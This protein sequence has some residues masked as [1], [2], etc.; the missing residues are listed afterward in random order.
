MQG[1]SD[2]R[3]SE[4][5]YWELVIVRRLAFTHAASKLQKKAQCE[6]L[7]LE[8]GAFPNSALLAARAA[9]SLSYSSDNRQT[10]VT[11]P[12]ALIS[13]LKK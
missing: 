3:S 5:A 9:I 4:E 6:P 8:F 10:F 12:E 7:A 13:M 2:R 11:K 1:A